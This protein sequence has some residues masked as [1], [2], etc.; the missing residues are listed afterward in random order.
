MTEYI[1]RNAAF[2]EA[3]E[4]LYVHPHKGD[5]LELLEGMPAADVV[6]VVRCKECRHFQPRG[7]CGEPWCNGRRVTPEYFCSDGERKELRVSEKI[8]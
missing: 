5:V 4:K 7:G 6:E 8:E 1:D 3:V 2:R